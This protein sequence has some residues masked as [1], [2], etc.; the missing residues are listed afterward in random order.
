MTVL[1]SDSANRANSTTTIG[2]SDSYAGGTNTAWTVYGG[3]TYGIKNN[4]IYQVSTTKPDYQ[5]A[6]F[7]MGQPD[8]KVTATFATI[9]ASGDKPY[10]VL[11]ATDANNYLFLMGG[12]GTNKVYE[13]G[14]CQNG[15]TTWTT[16]AQSSNTA[17]NGDVA[18]VTLNGNSI[19]VKINGTQVIN[20]T[21]S[22]Q[23]TGTLFGLCCGAQQI[24]TFDNFIIQNLVGT[25]QAYTKSLSD[26]I[27]FIE[28]LTKISSI[29]KTMLETINS[30]DSLSK[31]SSRFKSLN[32]SISNSDNIS[33]IINKNRIESIILNDSM[34]KNLSRFKTLNDSIITNDSFNK[35]TNR[36]FNDIITFSELVGKANIKYINDNIGLGESL[37]TGGN[38]SAI[39]NDI[40]TITDTII[41]FI[42]RNKSDGITLSDSQTRQLSRFISLSDAVFSTESLQ[43]NGGNGK[44]LSDFITLSDTI[45]KKLFKTYVDSIITNEVENDKT[46]KNFLES[47]S[48]VDNINI[49]RGKAINLSDF[50]TITESIKKSLFKIQI[51]NILASEA[52]NKA[53]SRKTSDLIDVTDLLNIASGKSLLLTDNILITDVIFKSVGKIKIENLLL[54]DSINKALGK[55]L[56]DIT[57]LNDNV[58]LFLPNIPEYNDIIEFILNINMEKT[59]NLNIINEKEFNLNIVKYKNFD[60]NI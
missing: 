4:Q 25:G 10:L 43:R 36:G 12:S 30:S 20:T 48:Q 57:I 38:K 15:G 50:V 52:E 35:L 5:F 44:L 34:S 17:V 56:F 6:G 54:M 49:F 37:N 13:L 23:S 18:E 41:K 2:T 19:I 60:L 1:V 9:P 28:S 29:R 53:V 32:D 27:N 59:F 3:E 26:S 24:T 55:N 22:A 31:I 33:K 14:L 16:I 51:D 7:N 11:R 21:T 39:L 46:M 42:S 8:V 45:S 47:I 40:I 58:T